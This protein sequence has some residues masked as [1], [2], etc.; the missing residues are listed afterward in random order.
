MGQRNKSACSPKIMQ[1]QECSSILAFQKSGCSCGKYEINFLLL[2]GDEEAFVLGGAVEQ[3][4][5][6]LYPFLLFCDTFLP[7]SEIKESL[8][9][10]PLLPGDPV[11]GGG[12][13]KKQALGTQKFSLV[14]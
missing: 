11:V 1:S 12:R 8:P 4:N 2:V 7:A 6:L 5:N 9:L 10:L 14:N 3:L 13:P